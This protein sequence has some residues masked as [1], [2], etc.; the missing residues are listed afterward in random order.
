[1]LS[2]RA[3][4]ITWLLATSI[5]IGA[6][7][8]VGGRATASEPL[9]EVAPVPAATVITLVVD[10]TEIT[11]VVGSTVVTQ[12]IDTSIITQIIDTSVITQIIGPSTSLIPLPSIPVA[13]S[14]VIAPELT[15]PILTTALT[16][17]PDVIGT[18]T[19]LGPYGV[20]V[21]PIV[22]PTG[23]E[24]AVF[25]RTDFENTRI[26]VYFD[27][28]PVAETRSGS[29]GLF[30]TS[31]AVP[32]VA[33]ATYTV[34]VGWVTDDDLIR[35]PI[36]SRAF[37]VVGSADAGDTPL[38]DGDAP[39]PDATLAPD[40]TIAPQTS[41]APAVTPGAV[42]AVPDDEDGIPAGGLPEVDDGSTSGP[43][44][45]GVTMPGEVTIDAQ[46]LGTSGAVGESV[47]TV[48]A[49]PA[50]G[51]ESVDG[52]GFPWLGFIGGFGGGLVLILAFAAGRRSRP[53]TPPLPPPG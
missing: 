48:A 49:L 6:Y 7:V 4:L 1:V 15:T 30:E 28:T 20:D 47:T 27:E 2:R 35:G 42:D 29:F 12:I 23:T 46:P 8:G 3:V 25:G 24:V 38:D 5:A 11:Q 39:G 36:A 17:D 13:T 44:Q 21:S 33:E 34:S 51:A 22:G 43:G 16:I 26:L 10:T 18:S 53:N 14:V 9:H 31:F 19:I 50:P 32:D 45:G 41:V 52:A 37:T 40:G